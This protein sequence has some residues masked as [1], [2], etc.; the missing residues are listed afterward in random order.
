MTATVQ[1]YR[2][3]LDLKA[4]KNRYECRTNQRRD[5]EVDPD[6]QNRNLQMIDEEAAADLPSRIGVNRST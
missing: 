4:E 6:R 1:L 2:V 5:P 3:K